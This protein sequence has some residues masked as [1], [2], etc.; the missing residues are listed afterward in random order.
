MLLLLAAALRET[1]EL[2]LLEL[3]LAVPLR[4]G[5]SAQAQ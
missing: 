4:T 3:G 2:D 1:R 5:R